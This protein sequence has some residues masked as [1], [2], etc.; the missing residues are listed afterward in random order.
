MTWLL[1]VILAHLFYAL[2]FII[3]KYILSR[4]LPHP[5]VYAFY[6][7][8]LSIFIWVL[9]P[10][11]FYIPS[12]R[13]IILVLLAGIAQV[14]GWIFFYRAL[15]KGEVSRIVPFVGSFVAI[16]ILIL[17]D[18]LS[19]EHLT[20]QQILAFV[21]LVLGSL[22]ISFKKGE[23]LK[24]F[25]H[26]VFGL[27][28]LGALLFAVFWVITKHIFLETSFVS[29]LIWI[30]TGV[31][32]VALTLLIPRKNRQLIFK[33]TEK[34]KPKTIK[35]FI[36]GRILSILASLFMYLAVFWGSVTLANSLQGVQYVFI[37]ILAFLFFKK[38]PKLK[39]QLSK[40]II[41]QKIIAII[42]I[43]LG[44]FILVS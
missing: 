31:A 40:E 13:E 41:V 25:F 1:I 21:F 26:G 20:N 29:G 18:F 27:A 3:D 37:L 36:S 30:R 33:K 42:L 5:I 7:G 4:P 44:L 43:G 6:I 22:I 2:V 38:F 14:A 9:F 39:E 17:S 8:I 28:F 12:F 34:L 16:F 15:N 11:G 32:F 24:G 35:F 23:F 19:V 10:F